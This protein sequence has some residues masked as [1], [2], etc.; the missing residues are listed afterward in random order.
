MGAKLLVCPERP[1]VSGRPCKRLKCLASGRN[2]TDGP[3]TSTLQQSI[4]CPSSHLLYYSTSVPR[5]YLY[6]S[7]NNSTRCQGRACAVLV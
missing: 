6:L 4:H 7:W 1:H 3:R 5:S 2:W